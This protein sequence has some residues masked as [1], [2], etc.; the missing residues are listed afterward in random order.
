M[1][2]LYSEAQPHDFYIETRRCVITWDRLAYA[3]VLVAVVNI[4]ISIL[5][6]WS[7]SNPHWA[8]FKPLKP[9]VSLKQ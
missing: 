2:Q 8:H 5:V 4:V 7:V 9:I 1:C 6:F 3:I